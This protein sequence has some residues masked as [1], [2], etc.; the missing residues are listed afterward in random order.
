MANAN[1]KRGAPSVVNALTRAL[2]A[3]DVQPADAAL[4]ALAKHYAAQLDTA[5]ADGTADAATLAK[6]TPGL[7]QILDAL[8]M[9]PKARRARATPGGGALHGGNISRTGG[10]APARLQQLRERADARTN[11]ATPLDPTA[12]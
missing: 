11:G 10:D 7:V 2:K 12:S 4:A 9:T 3:A 5:A 6:L 8:G 1:G